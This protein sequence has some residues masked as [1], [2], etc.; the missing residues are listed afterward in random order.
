MCFS[1][2]SPPLLD[3]F[4]FVEVGPLIALANLQLVNVAKAGFEP[5][6][7]LPS[8]PKFWGKQVC[9]RCSCLLQ[10]KANTRDTVCLAD[11]NSLVIL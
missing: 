4:V 3:L 7:L 10:W 8:L 2:S 5:L 1:L 11:N 9:S 6:I